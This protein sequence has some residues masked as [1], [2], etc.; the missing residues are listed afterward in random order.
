MKDV[1]WTNSKATFPFDSLGDSGMLWLI[2]ATVFHP[3]GLALTVHF[4]INGKATSWGLTGE[5][6]EPFVVSNA[7]A[8]ERFK[9]AKAFLDEY[10]A[11]ANVPT[12]S[13]GP[14]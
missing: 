5:G 9:L 7:L 14:I 13:D 8:V 11:V 1:K 6:D 4:D 2:N 3:R 10:L 12:S